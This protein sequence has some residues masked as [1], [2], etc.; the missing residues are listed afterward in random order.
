MLSIHARSNLLLQN[1]LQLLL[2]IKPAGL[3]KKKEKIKEDG[4]KWEHMDGILIKDGVNKEEEMMAGV[5]SKVVEEMA[6]VSKEVEV[7][8]GVNKAVVEE[9]MVGVDKVEE[10]EM[11]G[12][13]KVEVEAMDGANKVAEEIVDGEIKAEVVGDDSIDYL[14]NN[15]VIMRPLF[16]IKSRSLPALRSQ[17]YKRISKNSCH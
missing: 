4:I 10:E 3:D 7:M 14:I 11:A 8:A 9:M 5:V 17:I 13:S 6:G 15:D 1:K 16:K 12:V 2:D